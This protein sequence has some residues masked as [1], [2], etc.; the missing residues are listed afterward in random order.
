MSPF[1]VFRLDLCIN[2]IVQF[3]E[4]FLF[5]TKFSAS[6]SFMKKNKAES[7]ADV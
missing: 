5:E 3:I 1:Q 6:N 7:D 2:F 4:E